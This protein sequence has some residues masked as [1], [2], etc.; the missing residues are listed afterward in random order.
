MIRASWD[1]KCFQKAENSLCSL[2]SR[3]STVLGQHSSS[4][5]SATYTSKDETQRTQV[6]ALRPVALE[7]ERANAEQVLIGRTNEEPGR[8]RQQITPPRL[9]I[10]AGFLGPQRLSQLCF[11]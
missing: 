6:V 3:G 2:K 7:R 5:R 11:P 4:Q 8:Q 10:E 9:H 1:T